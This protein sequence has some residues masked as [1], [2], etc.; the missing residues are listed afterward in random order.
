MATRADIAPWVNRLVWRTSLE[1]L[2]TQLGLP[3]SSGVLK[4]LGFLAAALVS[5]E[6]CSHASVSDHSGNSSPE[7]VLANTEMLLARDLPTS[8]SVVPKLPRPLPTPGSRP[9]HQS[10]ITP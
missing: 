5:V 8:V 7:K 2:Q 6:I 3:V 1:L 10:P 9:T 4:I